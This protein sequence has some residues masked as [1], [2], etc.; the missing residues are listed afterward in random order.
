MADPI[1]NPEP[2]L[3]GLTYYYDFIDILIATY[4]YASFAAVDEDVA[5]A[6][7]AGPIAAGLRLNSDGAYE[8]VVPIGFG[9]KAI[10]ELEFDQKGRLQPIMGGFRKE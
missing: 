1:G 5:F 7:F 9:H 2:P 10:I 6:R 8:M 4:P 3:E